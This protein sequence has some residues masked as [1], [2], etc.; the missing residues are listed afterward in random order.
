MTSLPTLR[1][2]PATVSQVEQARKEELTRLT[3]TSV[4]ALDNV[5]SVNFI[6]E[7]VGRLRQRHRHLTTNPECSVPVA[8]ARKAK[9]LQC[10]AAHHSA[11][12]RK[13]P[14]FLARVKAQ[15]D[16]RLLSCEDFANKRKKK[17]ELKHPFYALTEEAKEFYFHELHSIAVPTANRVSEEPSNPTPATPPRRATA[18]GQAPSTPFLAAALLRQLNLEDDE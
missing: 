9:H 14:R 15:I 16:S 17:R 2:T 5:V 11:L 6:I 10:L 13:D 7:R 3:S 12:Q 4:T 8:S 1:R 18:T